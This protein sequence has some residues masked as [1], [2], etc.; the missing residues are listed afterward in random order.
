M[1]S[2]VVVFGTGSMAALL[3]FYL[4]HDSPHE[5]VAFTA[6]EPL[7]HDE[8]RARPLVSFE[9][10]TDAYPP[11][12]HAMF[13]AVGYRKRNTLRAR[14]YGE[15]KAKGYDLVSY[16]SS[17]ASLW[18]GTEVG[19]NWS[20]FEAATIAPFASIG[21]NVAVWNGAHVGHNDEIAD[22]CFLAPR[23]TVAGFVTMGERAFIGAGATVRDGVHIAEATLVGAG[24]TV[25]RDTER[26]EV[27]VSGRA[28]G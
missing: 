1:G 26:N 14:F 12:D 2:K 23:A 4:T 10:V 5:V 9:S 20:I 28:A 15:A 27:Y 21:N 16:V 7:D 19:E 24:A 11:G 13:V 3:D 25:L 8:F 22:H 6:T 17:R 18:E